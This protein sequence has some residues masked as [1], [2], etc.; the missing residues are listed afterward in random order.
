MKQTWKNGIFFMALLSLFSCKSSQD[1]S[2]VKDG[3][4]AKVKKDQLSRDQ[5]FD[6]KKMYYVR[7]KSWDSNRM[8]PQSLAD[9]QE[10][11]GSKLEVFET[12][13][14][15]NVHCPDKLSSE[16]NQVFES[17]AFRM[18]TSGN[19]TKGTDK[20]S[21]VF[22][23]K[24]STLAKMKSLSLKSMWN[25]PSQLREAIAWKF[26]Q[27][28]TVPASRHT[29][30][31]F[32][33]NDRYFGLYS[34]IEAVEEA[35][36]SANFGK[37]DQGN[38]YKAGVVPKDL[39]GADLS[40]KPSDSPQHPGKP[41]TKSPLDKRTYE[42][43]TNEKD[44]AV[45]TYNDFAALVAAINGSD[46]DANEREKYFKSSKFVNDL[47]SIFHWR[48]FLRWAAANMLLGS[49]DNYWATASNYYLYNVGYKADPQSFMTKPFFVWIPWDYDN[50]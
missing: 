41:Y 3:A 8:S 4:A 10:V 6:Q 37:N 25:D 14:H 46:V 40:F 21:Y 44:Q 15:A 12:D 7:V 38:L 1:E 31:K 26:F 36:L 32:C 24:N 42:L 47:S 50:S 23:W 34:I 22:K 30:A 11:A 39:G 29:W 49:W 33:I 35:F 43:K 27:Q 13:P 45:A 18:R 19:A 5:F 48:P 17:A 2:E 16:Q 28:M 20:S 9:W